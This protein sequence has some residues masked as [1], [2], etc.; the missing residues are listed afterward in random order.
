MATHVTTGNRLDICYET[1]IVRDEK[2]NIV[3]LKS[4]PLSLNPWDNKDLY[5]SLPNPV[6]FYQTLGVI[7]RER[8]HNV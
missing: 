7:L 5:I 1:I 8:G 2:G 6:S 4:G 3:D